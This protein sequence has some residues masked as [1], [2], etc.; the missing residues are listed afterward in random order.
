MSS[1]VDQTGSE[2]IFIDV[3]DEAGALLWE[4]PVRLFTA[5]V[6]CN[7]NA[8]TAWIQFFDAA[9]VADVTIGTTDPVLSIPIPSNAV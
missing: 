4:G 9:E 3:I 7:G 5:N 8:S 6:S 2:P 1:S